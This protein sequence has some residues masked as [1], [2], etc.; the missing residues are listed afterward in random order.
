MGAVAR[1]QATGC[2]TSSAVRA[3]DAWLT[4]LQ[5]DHAEAFLAGELDLLGSD[6]ESAVHR[7]TLVVAPC[8]CALS[9]ASTARSAEQLRHARQQPG[10]G[11]WATLDAVAGI[12]ADAGGAAMYRVAAAAVSRVG[13]CIT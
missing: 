2:S 10:T 7:A 4:A 5:L 13:S 12:S 1:H 6:Q 8:T 3:A 11:V 9:N